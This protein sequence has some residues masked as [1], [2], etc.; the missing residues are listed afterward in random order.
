MSVKIMEDILQSFRQVPEFNVVPDEQLQWMINKGHVLSHKDGDTI[1][2]PGDEINN[3]IFVLEGEIN[4]YVPQNG[5][6]RYL[7]TIETHEISGRLPYSRMKGAIGYATVK[8]ATRVFYFHRDH[9]PEMMRSHFE[10]TEVLVHYMMDRIRYSVKQQQLN[11]KLISLGKLSAGLAH[12]LNNPSAAVVRSATELKKHLASVP[13]KFKRVIRIRTTTEI[14]DKVNELLFSKIKPVTQETLSLAVKNRMEENIAAWLNEHDIEDAYTIAETFAEYRF[15]ITDLNALKNMLRPEDVSAVVNWLYQVLTTERFVNEIQEAAKRIN[16]L[17][18]SIKSYTH[19]DQSPD[20]E[21]AD[22]HA[23]IRNTLTMLNHKIKRNS[24]KV[25]ESF[26]QNLPRPTVY[27]SAMNQVFT[28]LIDNALDAMEERSNNVLEIRTKKDK[29]FVLVQI[30]DNG[31]G[32]PP[33]IQE[34]IFDP[35]FTTKP[36]GKGTGLGLEIVRQIVNQH[37]GKVTLK[38]EPGTTEFS[39]CIPIT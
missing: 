24:V 39:V 23:G 36:V 10:L 20:K 29:E 8:G 12:E 4:I 34:S 31:P 25:I 3:M 19:M 15:E 26:E 9:F 28:N 22:L 13:D 1:F 21:P 38:S 14:V 30:I 37:K 2:A 7:D 6:L 16:S 11:D 35:F 5:N 32:I 17:V 18:T 33:E 27:V